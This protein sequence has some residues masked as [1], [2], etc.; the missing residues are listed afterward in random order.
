MK[1]TLTQQRKAQV[2]KFNDDLNMCSMFA[3]LSVAIWQCLCN[4]AIQDSSLNTEQDKPKRKKRL[5]R[6]I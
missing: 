2:I 4:D 1:F 6:R 3:V 5:L